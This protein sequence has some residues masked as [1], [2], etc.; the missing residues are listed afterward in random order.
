MT[1]PART[2]TQ[3]YIQVANP[4]L[5]EGYIP[6]LN[7]AKGVYLGNALLTVRNGKAHLRVINTNEDDYDVFVPMI[8]IFEFNELTNSNSNSSSNS[9]SNSNSNFN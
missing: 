2:N 1:I 7:L 5:K 6:K 8:K 4:E 3:I 9:N